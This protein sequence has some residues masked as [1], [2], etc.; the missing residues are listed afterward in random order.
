VEGVLAT[1]SKDRFEAICKALGEMQAEHQMRG[2]LLRVVCQLVDCTPIDLPD[3]IRKMVT[4]QSWV[5]DSKTLR[6]ENAKL[7]L[8]VGTLISENQAARKQAEA[9]VAAAERIRMFAHQ[10]GKV[11]AKAELF[12]EKVGIRSKPSGTRIALILTDYSEKLERV[13]ADMREV[14]TQVTDLRRQPER[15]ELATSSSKGVPNL[16]KLS[17]P[18]SF[19]GLPM[20][21]DYT[22]VD[23]TPESKVVHGPKDARKGKSPGKK[24][25]DEIMT[26][27][28]K[29]VESGSGGEGFLIPDL[30]QRRG[31]QAFSPDQEMAGFR[32]PSLK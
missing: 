17:L 11:V 22:G 29:E 31:M 32:T 16:S 9:T 30:H 14:V 15:Q 6:Q 5:E 27:A 7:N 2:E 25:R 24:D 19:N 28:S 4:E 26:S 18:E 23:V 13:L 12:D 3:R 20:V 10:A 1:S 21:E 8:E